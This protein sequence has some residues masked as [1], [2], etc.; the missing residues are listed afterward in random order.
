MYTQMEQQQH[1]A[2]A[3]ARIGMHTSSGGGGGM[4]VINDGQ[5]P[6]ANIRANACFPAL[7]AYANDG[8]NHR[9]LSALIDFIRAQCQD[10]VA[11]GVPVITI[12][13]GGG[14]VVGRLTVTAADRIN[15]HAPS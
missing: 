6:V 4:V 15:Y 12:G 1:Q 2:F 7:S 11:D 5:A 9:K 10:P 14:G 13:Q 3:D 8:A